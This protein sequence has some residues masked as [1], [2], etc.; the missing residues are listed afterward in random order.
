[1]NLAPAATFAVFV[2]ISIYWLHESFLTAQAF[3][4]LALIGLLTGPMTRFIQSLPQVL[5]CVG[6]FNRIQE[7][8]NYTDISLKDENY[9]EPGYTDLRHE[10]EIHLLAPDGPAEPFDAPHDDAISLHSQGFKWNK[11][12]PTI[13]KDLQVDINR[14]AVTAITGPVGSAYCS[15]QPWLENTTVRQNILSSS[16]FV[17]KWY[18]EVVFAC[19]LDA[20]LKQLQRGD[21]TNIGSRGLNLSGGQKQRIALARAIY[22]KKRIILLDDVLSGMDAHTID[23]ISARLLGNEGILRKQRATVVLTTHHHFIIVL[24]NGKVT[25]KDTPASL[26]HNNGYVSKLGLQLI[27]DNGDMD[28][29]T[30]KPSSA[31]TTEEV[32]EMAAEVSI[33]MSEETDGRHTDIR[34]KKGELSVYAYYLA[35]SGWGSVIVYSVGVVGWILCIEFSTVWM[36]WWSAANTLEPNKDVWMYL[37]I[38]TLLGILGIV[39]GGICAWAAFIS[40][41]SRSA[42]QLHSNLLQTTLKAPFYSRST[43]NIGELLNSRDM[44]LIDMEL[45]NNMVNYTSTA[46]LSIAKVVI[47]AIFTRYLGVTIPFFA[48]FVY[49]LQSFYLQT[50]RQIR[51]LAIEAHAPLFTHFSESIAGAVTI[52]AFGW[53]SYHQERNYR[54]ID[55]S[56]RPAYLQSCIQHWLSFVLEIMTTVL[57]VLLVAT[58]V[59]WKDMFSPGSIGV[60]LVTVIGF[61]EV[62]VR[63]VKTWTTLEPSIGAVSRVKRF[64]E[65]TETEERNEKGAYV[66]ATW[67]QAGAIEFAG[68]TASYGYMI[69]S[70]EGSISIDGVDLS[71]L[72]CTEVRSRINVV[73]QDPFLLPGSI[74]FNVDPLNGASDDD[75]IRALDRVRL[76]TI[77]DEQG[78]IDKE[79]DLSSWSVGRK[80]LLCF[81]RA[82]VKKS[83]I[84]ILDE[85][86]SSVDNET[87]AIMQEIID[88]EFKE[89]TVLA[90]MHRLEH[91]RRYDKAALFGNGKLLEYDDP[92][93]LLSGDTN[94]AKLYSS[95]QS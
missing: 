68:W 5:Q 6:S 63:L 35:N 49:F 18:D 52:R 29:T 92:E 47:I 81:A 44:A 50:S 28:E 53:Q 2:I 87:E 67:P 83:K 79:I 25:A 32:F 8:C 27:S 62:L 22:A 54:L 23:I 16:S 42:A 75:I 77:V 51:L 36:K 85:A 88:T 40:I 58:V 78:G 48:I 46:I 82:M 43:S 72:A 94:L 74:R 7:Y 24:E 60:S 80:Q 9:S 13:L 70:D 91:I 86:M 56:Q 21:Q 1:M 20:D 11:N 57:V 15:Q 39:S 4:S 3:T 71:T 64:T 73:S 90:V 10:S 93:T 17:R 66:P 26:L 38:Y 14:E 76:W 30:T 34:R 41:I 65:E 89:C 33:G 45:P 12:G 59:V 84:L 55:A 95:Y 19:G 31:L 61:S 69:E 37:G